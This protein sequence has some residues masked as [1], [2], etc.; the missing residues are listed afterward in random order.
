MQRPPTEKPVT[1]RLGPRP[2]AL[3]LATAAMS[4]LLWRAALP[5]WKSGSL[6]WSPP[7]AAAAVRLRQDLVA[8]NDANPEAIA[9]A[10]EAELRRRFDAFL[11]GIETYRAHSDVRRES[12]PPV[13]W[14]E[15][16]TRLLDYG[17]TAPG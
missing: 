4:S 7:L 17:A 5:M 14:S 9:D 3:H 1:Q 2:L 11:R 15:S 10:V 8:R 16:A 6:P 12:D 13:V